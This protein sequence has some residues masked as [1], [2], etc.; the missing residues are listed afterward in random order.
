MSFRIV[1]L[2]IEYALKIRSAGEDDFGNEIEEQIAGGYGPCRVS[3]RPFV[4]GV[5]RRILVGHS[6]FER[7]MHSINPVRYFLMHRR[8]LMNTETFV[9]FRRRSRPTL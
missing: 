4:P 5:D 9:A 8:T 1:P 2:S 3:L 6:P 7:L